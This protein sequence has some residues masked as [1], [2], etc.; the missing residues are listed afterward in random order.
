MGGFIP[1]REK[2]IGS[3][4]RRD[5]RN[6]TSRSGNGMER[7]IIGRSRLRQEVLDV[8]LA[9]GHGP[10]SQLSNIRDQ[11]RSELEVFVG[12]LQLM[13][14]SCR[15]GEMIPKYG[16]LGTQVELDGIYKSGC[17]HKA[18]SSSVDPTKLVGNDLKNHS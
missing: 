3:A 6:L 8:V 4:K 13:K 16:N 12:C 5:C 14:N 15:I 2:E 9:V 18:G 7:G 11:L 17:G 10:A 1:D